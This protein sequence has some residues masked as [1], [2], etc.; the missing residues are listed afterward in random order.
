MAL[1]LAPEVPRVL[2][3]NGGGCTLWYDNPNPFGEDYYY[4][5]FVPRY[6]GPTVYPSITADVNTIITSLLNQRYAGE[7]EIVR[8]AGIQHAIAGDL[9]FVANP[10]YLAQ[11][12]T[13]GTVMFGSFTTN[14]AWTFA[15]VEILG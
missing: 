5:I 9:T 6:N 14:R 7:L 2:R 1:V 13:T 10:R 3:V 8:V 15:K 4:N 12:A 11:V